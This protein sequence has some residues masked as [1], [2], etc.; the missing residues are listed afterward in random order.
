VEVNKGKALSRDFNQRTRS[1]LFL[2]VAAVVARALGLSR[3]RAYENGVVSLNLA[4]SPQL[5]GGRATRSTH[6]RVLDGAGRLFT[7]LFGVP[8]TADNPFLWKTKAEVLGQIRAAGHGRLCAAAISCGG[9]IAATRVQ[10]HCGRCSQCVD[11]RLTG[12]AAGLDADMDPP[13]IYASDVLTGPRDG[14]E[15]TLIERYLGTALQVT[16][17][18]DAGEFVRAFPEV[19]RVFGHVALPAARAAA[20]IFD[21]YRRHAGQVYEALTHVVERHGADIV[22]YRLPP[23]CLLS[24]AC[25]RRAVAPVAATSDAHNGH[26]GRNGA[27]GDLIIDPTK[28]EVRRGGRPCFLGNTREFHLLAYLH[29]HYAEYVSV[30]DIAADVWDDKNTKKRTIHT[31]VCNLRRRLRGAGM[32]EVVIDGSEKGHYRLALQPQNVAAL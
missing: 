1:F 5:L 23:N 7:M 26:A 13:E 25:G 14:P 32:T 18:A 31:T 20:Q 4:I 16:R 9:T 2:S 29:A 8:F 24:L 28:L 22:R 12:L 6:P 19:T 30:Q 17:M 10:T 27:G 3:V 11:R 21:L 15:L